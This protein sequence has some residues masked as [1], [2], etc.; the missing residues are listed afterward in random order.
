MFGKCML[1]P[2]FKRFISKHE[3]F[4]LLDRSNNITYVVD[5]IRMYYVQT[6][7]R[8]MDVITAAWGVSVAVVLRY[9]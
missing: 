7:A 1:L 9:R 2:I 3:I 8:W 6:Y 5:T 4:L